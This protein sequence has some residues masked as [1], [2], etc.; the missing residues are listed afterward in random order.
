MNLISQKNWAESSAGGK[1]G[2]VTNKDFTRPGPAL[3][4]LCLLHYRDFRTCRVLGGKNHTE[5]VCSLSVGS[6]SRPRHLVSHCSSVDFAQKPGGV[7]N[8]RSTVAL[9][10]PS[11]PKY[12]QLSETVM[13]YFLFTI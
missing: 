11:F 13:A 10:F 12:S 8:A 7:S 5:S 4:P 9:L 6:Q 1:S 3:N 2:P